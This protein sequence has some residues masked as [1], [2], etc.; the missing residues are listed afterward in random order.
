MLPDE[1]QSPNIC[2][3]FFVEPDW[4][5]YSPV[6]AIDMRATLSTVPMEHHTSRGASKVLEEFPVAEEMLGCFAVKQ[7]PVFVDWSGFI[8]RVLETVIVVVSACCAHRWAR[9]VKPSV[10]SSDP[11]DVTNCATAVEISLCV[12]VLPSCVP[13]DTLVCSALTW[14]F[15]M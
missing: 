8:A 3:T 12:T 9:K 4:I 13:S 15:G 7:L 14:S 11:Y 5:F 1:A 6:L 10:Q 2:N